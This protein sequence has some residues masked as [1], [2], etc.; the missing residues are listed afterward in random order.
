MVHIVMLMH[1]YV[2]LLEPINLNEGF[3]IWVVI[4]YQFKNKGEL[5]SDCPGDP[6]SD[7]YT[8]DSI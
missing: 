3:A 7:I 5:P 6:Y 8:E 4:F 2:N 1:A